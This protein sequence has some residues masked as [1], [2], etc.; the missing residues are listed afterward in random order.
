ML[1][2]SLLVA[3]AGATAAASNDRPTTGAPIA[4]KW[5]PRKIHFMYSAIS[6]SSKTTFYSCDS[7]QGQITAILR[8]LGARDEVVKPFGCFTNGGPER[9]PGVEAT[10]SVLESARSDDQGAGSSKNVEAHWDKVTL[11]TPDTSCALLEQVK[12]RILPLFTTR[13]QTS[14]CSPRF[15]VEVLRPVKSPATDS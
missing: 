11:T 5:V 9:F 12:Q 14:G 10:F 7:L 6:S 1:A 3:S 15:S 13:N 4:A 8:Q 2:S